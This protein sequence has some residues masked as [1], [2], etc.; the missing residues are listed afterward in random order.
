MCIKDLRAKSKIPWHKKGR[1]RDKAIEDL[2]LMLNRLMSCRIFKI[3]RKLSLSNLTTANN[4]SPIKFRLLIPSELRLLR[5]Q[6]SLNLYRSHRCKANS[7]VFIQ[8]M[9]NKCLQIV[10]LNSLS[11]Q[12]R[13]NHLLIRISRIKMRGLLFLI[14]VA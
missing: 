2:N 1:T 6:S 10:L 11:Q 5:K 8:Q 4:H 3:V 14:S 9:L 12:K 13:V 7:I